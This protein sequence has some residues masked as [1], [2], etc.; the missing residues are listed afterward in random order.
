M[1]INKNKRS[2]LR[3]KCHLR[4]TQNEAFKS[5]KVRLQNSYKK[6]IVKNYSLLSATSAISLSHVAHSTTPF[7]QGYFVPS[8]WTLEKVIT[9]FDDFFGPKVT[10]TIR[11][12]NLKC[13]REVTTEIFAWFKISQWEKQIST[14][15]CD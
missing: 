10:P 15:S 4:M 12:L 6:C 11:M 7:K 2:F 1:T 13:S 3:W 14:G 9:D 5:S 8:L